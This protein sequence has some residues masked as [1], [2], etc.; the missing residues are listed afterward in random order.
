MA[1]IT[2]TIPSY[3]G[4]ISQQADELKVPGQVKD[5][6]NVIPDLTE[7]L[8]KRPGGRLVASLSD[9]STSALNAEPNGKWFH[10]Y[11]DENEQYIGQVSRA[12]DINMWKCSDGSA[13][14]VNYDSGKT[15]ELTNYLTHTADAD[16]QTLTLND[17]TYI[18]NRTKTVAMQGNS[19][20]VNPSRPAE[21]YIELKK[22]AYASQYSVNLFDD[23]T[24]QS[25]FTAT[26]ITVTRAYDSS[27][28]C[29]GGS[30]PPAGNLPDE[31]G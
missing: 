6:I 10:Y 25:V 11:R 3:N 21:A 19:G 16:I 15:T 22:V 17:F 29:T 18:A 30:L 27:N 26:R 2:Q 31:G 28:G 23:N 13:I 14:T 5:A 1:T 8:Q 9:N 20:S 7:G 24:T 12:G 4:G